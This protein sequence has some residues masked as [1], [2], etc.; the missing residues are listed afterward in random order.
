MGFCLFE[1][2]DFDGLYLAVN[3][4]Y[5]DNYDQDG[6]KGGRPVTRLFFTAPLMRDGTAQD[7]RVIGEPED[8]DNVLKQA[9]KIGL[10]KANL[11]ILNRFSDKPM[12]LL[13]NNPGRIMV[14]RE[15]M[16]EEFMGKNASI[17]TASILYFEDGK[18]RFISERPG[19]F[20]VLTNQGSHVPVLKVE[21]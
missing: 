17:L 11:N 16:P 1:D 8:L 20:C 2:A 9:T 6:T 12:P 13:I 10:S 4:Q 5:I 7:I 15:L 19:R 14:V 21:L 3:C 18:N